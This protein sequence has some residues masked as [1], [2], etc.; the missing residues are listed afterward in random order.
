MN[1]QKSQDIWVLPLK[2]VSA[3][4]GCSKV[5]RGHW[6]GVRGLA[7]WREGSQ[8]IPRRRARR[9][10]IAIDVPH[11]SGPRGAAPE[12]RQCR[13]P[14]PEAGNTIC[15]AGVLL[16]RDKPIYYW[17]SVNRSR[18]ATGAIYNTADQPDLMPESSVPVFQLSKSKAVRA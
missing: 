15:T 2:K 6:E 18:L 1:F 3:H 7:G 14:P 13:I 5:T 4:G 16:K 11:P 12:A 9:I 10:I 17:G 8:T